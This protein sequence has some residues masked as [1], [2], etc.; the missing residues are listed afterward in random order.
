MSTAIQTRSATRKAGPTTI[1]IIRDVFDSAT[2]R[3]T[4]K[5]LPVLAEQLG[6]HPTTV[7]LQFYRWRAESQSPAAKLARGE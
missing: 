2:S 7:R 6:M 3:I 1:G 5:H 4:S